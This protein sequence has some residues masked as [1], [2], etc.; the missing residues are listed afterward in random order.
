VSLLGSDAI[1]CAC[2]ATFLPSEPCCP[3]CGDPIDEPDDWQ[4]E[5]RVDEAS[6][7]GQGPAG[8]TEHVS[9]ADRIRAS[10][11]TSEQISSIPPPDPLVNGLLTLNSLAMLY[12]GSGIGKSFV[13]ADLALH[14]AHGAHWQGRPVTPGPVM[15]VVAEGAASFGPRLTAWKKHHQLHTEPHPIRWVP[16]AINLFEPSWAGALAEVVAEVRPVMLV[17]DTYARSIVGAEE[18]S[19][20][21]VGHIVANLDHI[22]RAAACCVLLVHHAGKDSTAGARGSS[23]LRGAMDTEL[24]L[25]GDALYLQLKT[26][27]QKDGP[28]AQ[29]IGLRL[30]EVPGTKSVVVVDQTQGGAELPEKLAA[31]LAALMEADVP[32]GLSSTQ[33]MEVADVPERTFYRHRSDLL[34]RSLVIDIT[35]GSKTPKYRPADGAQRRLEV[36]QQLD[37]GEEF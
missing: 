11:L 33:W 27:K 13:A 6:G 28:E 14:I 15:Y 4:P 34:K 25:A 20:K 16:R 12:G 31:T 17:V 29:P 21:D 35:D 2:G 7:T 32:Q 24:E 3:Q 23:A 10:I 18:N 19:S 9:Q 36:E 8:D 30:L 1:H 26:K 22:R 37:E 5:P